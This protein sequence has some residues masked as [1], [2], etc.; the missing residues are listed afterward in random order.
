[1]RPYFILLIISTAFFL[2][3]A[4]SK[5]GGTPPPP[6]PDPCLSVNMSLSGAVSNPSAFGMSDGSITVSASGGTGFTFSLNGGAFQSSVVFKYLAAGNYSI[7]ARNNDG[8][9]GTINFVLTNPGTQCSGV[10]ISV[11]ATAA[12]NIPCE[13]NNGSITIAAT[14]STGPYTFSLNGGAYQAG[15]SFS[16]LAAGSYSITV[17]DANGCTGSASI[18][19]SNAAAGPLFAQVKTLIR[20]ECVYCHNNAA[21][22][23]INLSVDCNI[24]TGSARIKARAADGIPSAMPQTGL[25]PA[26]QRQKIID[27]ITAGGKFSN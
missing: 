26:I 20:D 9:T 11:A 19:L 1:M 13:P 25:L 18:M 21:T 4:C 8:C 22:N 14:G 3:L 12:S 23:G 5:T 2:Q 17:K 7:T 24:V 27:W 15:N 10:S 6:P 16:N